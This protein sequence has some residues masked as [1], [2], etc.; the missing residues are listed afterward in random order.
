MPRLIPGA[1]PQRA[2]QSSSPSRYSAG[3]PTWAAISL[4]MGAVVIHTIGEL[5]Y[6]AGGFE[7]SFALAP[8]HATGQY[9]GVF[10]VGAGLGEALGASLLVALCISWGRPGWYVVGALFTVTGLAA[11]MTVRWAERGKARRSMPEPEAAGAAVHP[12]E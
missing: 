3:T 7:V 12:P 5:W 4:L 2:L 1:G 10:G 9:L 6:A 8:D 11:P